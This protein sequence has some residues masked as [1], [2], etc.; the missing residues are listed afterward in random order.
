M[1]FG[2]CTHCTL[3]SSTLPLSFLH[4]QTRC[5]SRLVVPVHAKLWAS[6]KA[7]RCE[8]S[9]AGEVQSGGRRAAAALCAGLLL[10]ALQPNA[11]CA[12]DV[13]SMSTG[14]ASRSATVEVLGS[15]V[16]GSNDASTLSANTQARRAAAKSACTACACFGGM[17]LGKPRMLN[18]KR[19]QCGVHP[20]SSTVTLGSNL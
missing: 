1:H 7:C 16:S 15:V 20:S 4:K 19:V 9:I 6:L 5:R 3:C 18:R 13:S 10:Q 17:V 2:T 14:T 12:M 11:A 8:A